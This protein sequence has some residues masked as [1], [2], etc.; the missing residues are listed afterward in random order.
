M[1]AEDHRS[2]PPIVAIAIISAA[3]LGYEILLLRLFAIIQWHHFASMIISLALLGF[4]ASGTFLAL[5]GERVV[6]RFAA[7]FAANAVLFGGTSMG[8]VLLAQWIPFNPL[9]LPWE[10]QQPL[11]LSTV[12]LTLAVPFFFAANC[13]GL[14]IC[15]FP[16]RIGRVYGA[17][18][19]G[20]AAGALGIVFLLFVLVPETALQVIATMGPAAAVCAWRPRS[21]RWRLTIAAGVALILAVSSAG[22][23]WDVRVS[24]YKGLSQALRVKGARVV[25]ERSSPLGLLTVVESPDV[26]FR[27]APGLSLESPSAPPDQLGL[28]TDGESLTVVSRIPIDDGSTPRFLAYLT[29]ALPYSLVDGPRVLVLG[30]GGGTE[31]L[32]ALHHG[33]SHVDAVELNADVVELMRTDLAHFSGRLYDRPRVRVHVG[34][35]RSFALTSSDRYDVIQIALLDGFGAASA[36]LQALNESYVYTIEAMEAY[37]RR[38]TP[39]GMLTV[40]RW[41]KLPPRDT[42]KLFGTAVAALR[43]SGV[44][45]EEARLA[46][47]RSWNTTTLLVRNGPFIAADVDAIR[48]FAGERAFDIAYVPG[49]AL[50]EANRFNVLDRPFFGE[51]ALALLGSEAKSYI[52]GYKYDIEPATDDRPFFFNFFRWRL[53]PEL[54]RLRGRG[55]LGLLEWGYPVL[56]ATLA[57]ALVVAP[58]LIVLPLILARRRTDRPAGPSRIRVFAYFLCLGLAFLLL[59]MAFIQRFVLFLGHPLYA[60]AAV[61]TAFLGFAGLG[62]LLSSRVSRLARVAGV[63][64]ERAVILPVTAIAVLAVGYVIGLPLLFEEFAGWPVA[65]RF[66]LSIIIIGPL[67][68]AM[69]MPFP[70]GLTRLGE[71]APDMVPWAWAINGCASVLAAVLAAILAIE[72]GFSAVVLAAIAFYALAARTV[73]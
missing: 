46:L 31:V 61:L 58:L 44:I 66:A 7:L 65:P 42:L 9:A 33:A 16:G 19:L 57:Q 37:L 56:A 17:D 38:L 50:E 20:A 27:H 52:D 30:A 72:L 62:S 60:A 2:A 63:A 12:Y 1:A 25:T 21:C 28:F 69:G 41:M 6:S 68:L 49:M 29:S 67:A 13:I 23:W 43:R 64:R 36:G 34:D 8:S 26:P 48:R 4:G 47:V 53:V 10:W 51:G 15:R 11:L 71:A 35:A 39:G 32:Q 40:T 5:A 18:L 22:A 55:G 3:A 24:S 59:E 45:D 54:V 14:A 73:P 70:L